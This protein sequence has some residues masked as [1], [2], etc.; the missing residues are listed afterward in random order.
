MATKED[1]AA[2]QKREVGEALKNLNT[3]ATKEMADYP[4]SKSIEM[5]SEAKDKAGELTRA[6]IIDR[7][8]P[9]WRRVHARRG[10]PMSF[11]P[12]SKA[13]KTDDDLL[14]DYINL[15]SN[16]D[17]DDDDN[18]ALIG[19]VAIEEARG[20]VLGFFLL[21]WGSALKSGD[22]TAS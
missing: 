2:K 19:E 4:N 12:A 15:M 18:L 16:V 17:L 22:V 6:L 7:D 10:L 21:L 3:E 5:A 9:G 13:M 11:D 8:I 14:F 1:A 20:F